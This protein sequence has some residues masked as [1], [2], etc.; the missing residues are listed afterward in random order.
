MQSHLLISAQTTFEKQ[1]LNLPTCI[2]ANQ[3]YLHCITS[4]Q[5]SLN[6][7]KK[8]LLHPISKTT[9]ISKYTHATNEIGSLATDFGRTRI[10][11][12]VSEVHHRS[13]T[14]CPTPTAPWPIAANSSQSRGIISSRSNDSSTSRTG[15][16]QLRG[17][18]SDDIWDRVPDLLLGKQ[19]LLLPDLQSISTR[20]L[21][22]KM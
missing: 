9:Y 12:T 7:N 20:P 22:G 11:D 5:Q 13:P 21:A 1:Y 15:R 8:T 10:F 14:P 18:W 16:N 3:T 19:Y 6:H 4:K 2:K 17:T